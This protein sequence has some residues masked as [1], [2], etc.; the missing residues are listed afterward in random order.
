MTP[1]AAVCGMYF[2]HP[3]ARYFGVG[4][5]HEDQVNDYAA[6]L[7]LPLDEVKRLLGPSLAD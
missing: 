2:G 5:I 4:T 7:G 1:A 3:A 6:R